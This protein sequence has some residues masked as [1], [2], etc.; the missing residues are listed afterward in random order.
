ML[1]SRLYRL[2]EKNIPK[3]EKVAL[4]Q[5]PK[6]E[7]IWDILGYYDYKA[8]VKITICELEIEK[9]SW[10]V[11]RRLGCKEY[12]TRL[13]LR[14]LVRLHE[15]AHSLT[16]TGNFNVFREM[17]LSERLPEFK[18]RRRFKMGYPIPPQINEPFAE[19]ISWSIIQNIPY[20]DVR[21]IF[22]KVFDEV[23]SDKQTPSY[24][25]RWIELKELLRELSDNESKPANEHYICFVPV[26]VHIARDSVWKDFEHFVLVVKDSYKSLQSMY[27]FLHTLEVLR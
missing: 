23:N 7:G 18:V 25:M 17:N 13:V 14:E 4:S 2:F 3:P 10:Q 24:Y 12:E 27:K 1:V 20:S 22:E 19:F 9:Y 26:L 5:C 8:Q 11:A 6:G 21:A 16:H 15:H